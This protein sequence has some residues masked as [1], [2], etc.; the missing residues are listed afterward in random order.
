MKQETKS[1][2]PPTEFDEFLI[3]KELNTIEKRI[4]D[5]FPPELVEVLKKISYQVAEIGL[6]ERESCLINDY[7]HETFLKL[8]DR[9]PVVVEL[10]EI[11]DLE[12]KK[13]LLKHISK[14]AQE[15]D[16][17]VAQWLLMAR[18]GDEFN[19]KKGTGNNNN[20]RGDDLIAAGIEFV[21]EHGDSDNL[22]TKESGRAFVIKKTGNRENRENFGDI[23]K[24]LA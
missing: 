3:S 17:K 1:S 13:S 4:A 24:L 12:Y 14:K 20:D 18:Y 10:M 2:L 23:K 11:K 22:V 5:Q 15:G 7:S 8:K 21:R 16:D 19:L 9:Y 6:T